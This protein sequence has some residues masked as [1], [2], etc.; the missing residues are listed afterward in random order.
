MLVP[1]WAVS[2]FA[3]MPIVQCFSSFLGFQRKLKEDQNRQIL[4]TC[5]FCLLSFDVLFGLL[6]WGGDV[7][8]L[9]VPPPKLLAF[10]EGLGL[11][12]SKTPFFKCFLKLCFFLC[13]FLSCCLLFCFFVAT[14]LP[15]TSPFC[16]SCCFHFWLFCYCLAFLLL[17]FERTCSGPS[18]ELQQ[19]GVF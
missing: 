9:L 7:L 8:F 3:E 5:N 4:T 13:F 11:F 14:S 1:I 18:Q 10:L 15:Q 19:H 16:N 6:V 2:R 12:S 17:V